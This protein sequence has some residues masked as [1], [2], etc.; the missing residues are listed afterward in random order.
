M[1]AIIPATAMTI[2]CG[3]R[4]R[5]RSETL[6]ERSSSLPPRLTSCGMKRWKP[7]AA[8]AMSAPRNTN[9]NANPP[10]WKSKPPS[11][12]PIIYPRPVETSQMPR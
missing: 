1:F 12:G 11:G 10:M 7:M 5:P 3:L 9:G 6:S 4:V 2:T 8:G